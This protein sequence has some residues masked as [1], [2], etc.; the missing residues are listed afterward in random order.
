MKH[1]PELESMIETEAPGGVVT[2]I[3][4]RLHSDKEWYPVA[5]FSKTIAPAEGNYKIH[6]KEMLAIVK[7]LDDAYKAPPTGSRSTLATDP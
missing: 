6:D 4:S 1:S 7:S 3:L 2:E 5:F